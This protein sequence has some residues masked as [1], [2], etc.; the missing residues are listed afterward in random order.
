MERLSCSPNLCASHHAEPGS[1]EPAAGGGADGK[2]GVRGDLEGVKS[3]ETRGGDALGL[4][5]DCPDLK[6]PL[7]PAVK[8]PVGV[9]GGAGW[10]PYWSHHPR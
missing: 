6:L 4:F 2:G 7:A 5:H 8:R 1:A 3:E 10:R 9:L